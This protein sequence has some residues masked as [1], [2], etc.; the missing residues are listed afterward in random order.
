VKGGLAPAGAGAFT[1]GTGTDAEPRAPSEEPRGGG[2]GG[3]SLAGPPAALVEGSPGRGGGGAGR[4]RLPGAGDELPAVA[5]PI[6]GK[7]GPAPGAGLG[8][9]VGDS[10]SEG[11]IRVLAATL[12]RV[13]Y[14]GDRRVA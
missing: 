7:P 11:G 2:M 10:L 14:S 4:G 13:R 8:F 5:P 3:G 9:T 12:R 6:A 1:A